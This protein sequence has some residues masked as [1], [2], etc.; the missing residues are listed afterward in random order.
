MLNHTVVLRSNIC[1]QRIVIWYLLLHMATYL[2]KIATIKFTI[3]FDFPRF[4]LYTKCH[5]TIFQLVDNETIKYIIHHTITYALSIVRPSRV[6]SYDI[7]SYWVMHW[8]YYYIA[9]LRLEFHFLNSK[10]FTCSI[11]WKRK[12]S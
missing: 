3:L 11:S 4:I 1:H 10:F 9:V 7:I 8:K 5:K 6:Y 2:W 12:L